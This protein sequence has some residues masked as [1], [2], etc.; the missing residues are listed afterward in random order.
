MVSLL[1]AAVK[2][3]A[4]RLRDS[5]SD[6]I[7]LVVDYVKQETVDP[8]RALGKFLAYGTVGA[9]SMGLGVLFL[10]VA[11]LR[12]LQEETSVFHGNLSW[13]PYFL[14]LIFALGVLVFGGWLVTAGPARPR[15]RAQKSNEDKR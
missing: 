6:S 3:G 4:R 14:V 5:G 15:K 9:F 8:I 2:A 10:L 13:I 12:A 11:V 1:G 7:Q